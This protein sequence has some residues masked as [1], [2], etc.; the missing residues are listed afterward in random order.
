VLAKLLPEN[1]RLE[2]IWLLSKIDFK[3]RYYDN[4]LG[5]LWALINP[6]CR[7]VIYYFAFTYIFPQKGI[8]NYALYLFSGLIIWFFFAQGTR[9]GI[10][11]LKSKKYLI[12]SIQFK[13]FD[14]F[15]ASTLSAFYS[16]VFNFIAYFLVSMIK[17]VG[18]HPTVFWLPL[19]VL[20]IVLLVLAISALLA[21]INIYLRD[22]E[23]FWDIVVLAGFWATPII[24]DSEIT[25]VKM[26]FLQYINPVAGIVINIRETVLYGNQPYYHLLVHDLVYASVLFIIAKFAYDKFS[27]KAVEKL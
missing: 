25:M 11:L 23:H 10:K 26:P 14:L 19:L 24:Y 7:F 6:L 9:K 18:V 12:E 22:I 4:G 1:N 16:F 13:H 20:N 21:T 5:I 8:K 3:K 27:H 17:G 15:V 2:R